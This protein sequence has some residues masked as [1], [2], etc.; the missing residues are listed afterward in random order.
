MLSETL[1]C[2]ILVLSHDKTIVVVILNAVVSAPEGS[3]AALEVG[4]CNDSNDVEI[5]S[6]FD[7]R[8]RNRR[9]SILHN[10]VSNVKKLSRENVERRSWI[11]PSK[12]HVAEKVSIIM[13]RVNDQLGDPLASLHTE[14]M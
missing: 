1:G 12:K 3:D 8:S 6:E 9:I 2:E 4:C 5:D 14:M 13:N 7:C 10:R 11:V